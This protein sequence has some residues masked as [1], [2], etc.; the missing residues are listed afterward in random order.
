MARKRAE[1]ASRGGKMPIETRI[2]KYLA[3]GRVTLTPRQLRRAAH[4]AHLSTAQVREKVAG[5]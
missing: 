5:R 2:E 4:K 1:A 3:E